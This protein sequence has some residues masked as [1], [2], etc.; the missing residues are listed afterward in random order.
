M[1]EVSRSRDVV[2]LTKIRRGLELCLKFCQALNFGLSFFLTLIDD[3]QVY[4]R[5]FVE[6]T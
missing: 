6:I 3:T 5:G 1:D 4:N 2:Q